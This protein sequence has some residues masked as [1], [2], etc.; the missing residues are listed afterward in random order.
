MKHVIF[1]IVRVCK[2]DDMVYVDLCVCMR[3]CGGIDF[4]MMWYLFGI[5]KGQGV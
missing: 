2:L 5:V 1:N 4:S 3:I